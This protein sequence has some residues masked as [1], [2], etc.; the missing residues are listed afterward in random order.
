MSSCVNERAQKIIQP[1]TDWKL[2]VV[3][4]REPMA[5]W[6]DGRVPPL[7]DAAHPMLR[8]MAQRACMAMEYAVRLS[9]SIGEYLDDLEK[10]LKAYQSRRVLR[11]ARVQLQSRAM[12]DHVYHPSG[13]HAAL[14]CDHAEQDIGGLVQGPRLA[15]RRKRG[16]LIKIL[17]T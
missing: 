5:N 1:G 16:R 4:D 7:G 6:V 11:T 3:C 2:W 17:T 15:V 14:R 13:A 12:G 9:H 8:Y 10:A